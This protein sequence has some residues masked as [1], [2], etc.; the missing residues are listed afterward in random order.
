MQMHFAQIPVPPTITKNLEHHL[1]AAS[2]NNAG[3]LCTN[4]L[5]AAA[6]EAHLA[7]CSGHVNKLGSTLK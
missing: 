6:Q 4:T 5:A 7:D 2:T 3:A 1:V